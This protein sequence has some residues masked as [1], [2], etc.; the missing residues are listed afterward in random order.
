[1]P[2]PIIIQDEGHS[3]AGHHP[4]VCAEINRFKS[5]T[6]CILTPK[7][8]WRKA[9][10]VNSLSEGIPTGTDKCD[11]QFTEFFRKVG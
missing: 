8:C 4:F 7:A 9:I 5:A 6:F 2:R 1:M 10:V 11:L 3:H